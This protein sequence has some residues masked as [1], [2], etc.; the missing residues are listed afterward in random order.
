MM[1][2]LTLLAGLLTLW[3]AAAPA[4]AAPPEE[5]FKVIYNNFNDDPDDLYN[6]QSGLAVYDNGPFTK[7]CNAR[8]M[9]FTPTESGIIQRVRI[10]LTHRENANIVKV[11]LRADADG[12][13][14]AILAKGQLL[15]FPEYGE[16]CL[17][18]VWPT[19]GIPVVAG[20]QYWLAV[21]ADDDSRM[22]WNANNTG[23]VGTVASWHGHQWWYV[24]SRKP[25]AFSVLG[26]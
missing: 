1:K 7:C 26:R 25:G 9:P 16:C 17:T 21:E 15:D 6:T 13:P 11:S 14:G 22:W 4:A 19:K 18:K 20:T 12:F 8:A 10:G 5:G 23:E 24:S 3:M 2:M